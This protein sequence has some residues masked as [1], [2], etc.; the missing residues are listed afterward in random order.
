MKLDTSWCICEPATRVQLN[1]IARLSC[2]ITPFLPWWREMREYS[3][4]GTPHSLSPRMNFER[5]R[6]ETLFSLI[7]LHS[8]SFL[9]SSSRDEIKGIDL[10]FRESCRRFAPLT[11]EGIL[12][13]SV[14]QFSEGLLIRSV[15]K[16][17][18]FSFDLLITSREKNLQ[19]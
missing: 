18:W 7:Y 1:Y 12:L 15:K 5:S 6:E 17:V 16:I 10:S 13:R 11:V 14:S 4:L 3:A 8:H 2:S 19:Q 9:S